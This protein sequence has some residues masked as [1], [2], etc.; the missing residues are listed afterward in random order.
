MRVLFDQG[1]PVPLRQFLTR[2]EVVTAYERGWSTLKNGELLDAAEKDGFEVLVTT[3]TNLQYQQN[4]TSRRI[5]IVVLSTPSWLRIQR[6]L[7]QVVHT[8]DASAKG[9]FTEVGIP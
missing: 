1:T 6:A 9:A 4:L 5:A 3:D 2:H 8:V 7:S